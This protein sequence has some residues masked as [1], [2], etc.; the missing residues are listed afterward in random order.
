MVDQTTLARVN[1]N[2]LLRTLEDL[3]A[4]R[5]AGAG[6]RRRKVRDDPVLGRRRG[7][8]QAG[9]RRGQNHFPA[10]PGP[11]SIKLWFPRPENLNAMFAG[12]GNP[13][14][15]KG[16]TKISYLKGPFTT[17]TDRLGYY[18]RT[19]PEKLKDKA[20]RDANAALS[21]RSAVFAM[22]EI[23]NS[24][25]EG[26]LNAGRMPDGEI[27]LAAG[28]GPELTVAAK[29]GKLVCSPGAPAKARARMVFSD[30]EA[31]GALLRGE[32]D[33]YAAIGAEK[34]LLGGYVPLLDNL[35]KIL[36]LVPRYLR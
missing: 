35:N 36:G 15:L 17:L 4:A 24:D 20:Y 27:L 25:R 22:G 31:A 16:L 21:L 11:C 32:L 8:R 30:L 9:D 23:G 14:P 29:G 7:C 10:G 1:L 19:T 3:P 34:L 33:S 18:L 2:A 28:G 13:I 26:K 6:Y 5:F 12:T